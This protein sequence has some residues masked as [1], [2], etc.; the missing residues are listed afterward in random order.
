MLALANVDSFY[1]RSHVL[2]DVS[3]Q[4]ERNKILAVLGRNGS[5]KTTLLKTIMGQTS[6][7]TGNIRLHECEIG[8]SADAKSHR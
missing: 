8:A 1:N 5:G 7:S 3:L 4:V 2:H 6:C